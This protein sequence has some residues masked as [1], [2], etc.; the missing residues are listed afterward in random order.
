MTYSKLFDPPLNDVPANAPALSFAD[1]RDSS[2]YIYTDS[3]VLAVNVAI[4]T[5]RPLRVRGPSGCGKSTLARNVAR[6]LN[7]P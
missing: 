7:R 3:I 1:R 4:A 5:G 2:G 6:Q